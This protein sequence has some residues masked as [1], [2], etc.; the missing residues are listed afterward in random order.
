V[1]PDR[2]EEFLPPELRGRGGRLDGFDLA[3]KPPGTRGVYVRERQGL[4][5]SLYG[6]WV[7]AGRSARY[8]VVIC[9]ESRSWRWPGFHLAPAGGGERATQREGMEE[10]GF[11]E[12]LEFTRR[13][14]V[15]AS[16]SGSVRDLFNRE[17]R[18]ATLKLGECHVSAWGPRLYLYAPRRLV[19][20]DE[21]VEW[22]EQA[23]V[24]AAGFAAAA[25][26]RPSPAAAPQSFT[27]RPSPAAPAL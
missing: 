20:D 11:P 12:D 17:A 18:A 16:E 6:L 14:V 1:T 21:T 23:G 24:L 19:L 22:L 5:T 10:V 4:R 8:Y 3:G 25:L 26:E 13:W 27:R 15:R 9:L 2:V 7:G